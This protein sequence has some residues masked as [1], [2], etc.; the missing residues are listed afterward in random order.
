M[1]LDTGLDKVLYSSPGLADFLSGKVTFKTRVQGSH[2][3]LQYRWKISWHSK[4]NPRVSKLEHFKFQDVRIET[5]RCEDWFSSFDDRGSR[6][7]VSM[8]KLFLFSERT[9]LYSQIFTLLISAAVQCSVWIASFG[10]LPISA[11]RYFQ[12]RIF[13]L[14][15]QCM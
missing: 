9:M 7:K 3:N 12:F 4:L 10:K 1:L 14:H 13:V 11:N 2:L 5:G 15:V 8:V 6:S